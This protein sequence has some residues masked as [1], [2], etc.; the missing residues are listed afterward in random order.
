MAGNVNEWVNDWYDGRYYQYSP[1][2]NPE[3]PE[4]GDSKGARGGSW[5]TVEGYLSSARR[6][7]GQQ[8]TINRKQLTINDLSDPE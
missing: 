7:G 1:A 4:S 5:L 6:T 2:N 8:L 3:G